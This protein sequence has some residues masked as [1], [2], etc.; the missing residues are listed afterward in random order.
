MPLFVGTSGWDYPEWKGEFYPE[1][2]RHARFLEYYSSRL[3]ACEINSTF[4]GLQSKETFERWIVSTPADFRFAVKAHRRLTHTKQIGSPRN[5]DFLREFIES[6]APLGDRLACLLVQFPPYRERDDEGLDRLLAGI[7]EDLPCALEFRHD[8]WF[9]AEVIERA[10]EAGA[11]ICLS[12]ETG[13]VPNEL[14]PGPL[15]YVRLRSSRYSP[16]EREGWLSLLARQAES[17]DVY[18][19]AKHRDV[20]ANDPFTGAGF[21]QWLNK[22]ARAPMGAKPPRAFGA[23]PG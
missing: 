9:S 5:D 22:P 11:T 18:A 3:S 6:L 17:R 13:S 7:P 16:E 2:L 15:A 23:P 19:F 20:A 1:D 4:Y 21:A 8:S 14:P 10:V 12:D